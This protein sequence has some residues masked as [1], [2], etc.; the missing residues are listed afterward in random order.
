MRIGNIEWRK[1]DPVNKE[2]SGSWT[3]GKKVSLVAMMFI[4]LYV[5]AVIPWGSVAIGVLHVGWFLL[6]WTMVIT[7]TVCAIRFF[8]P[9]FVGIA[10]IIITLVTLAAL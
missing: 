4:F 7:V 3:I 10:A 9:V 1:V 8:F 6:K 2:T 5:A